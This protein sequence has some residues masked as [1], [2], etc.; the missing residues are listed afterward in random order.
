[1]E[2]KELGPA[3]FEMQTSDVLRQTL[4]HLASGITGIASSSRQELIL[5]VGQIVQKM[6]AG[7]CLSALLAEW[8]KY[9]KQGRIKDDYQFTEQHKACLQ[10]MLDFLDKDIPDEI[11]FRMMKQVFLVGA[12]E[13]VSDRD[14]HLPLQ[15]IKIARS[16][17]SGEVLVLQATYHFAKDQGLWG[18]AGQGH[19]P[20]W[21]QTIAEQSGL[22]YPE[23]V[24]SHEDNLVE[25]HLLTKRVHADR[26]GV[27]VQPYFRLTSLGYNFCEYVDNYKAEVS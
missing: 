12:T 17:S 3:K 10:E 6:I 26:S 18:E 14:S 2:K 24:E 23:L 5:S 20:A 13:V 4:S 25:K 21:L 15:F 1:V 16:L 9:K 27:S 19:A 8:D 11:R 7:Q 22:K